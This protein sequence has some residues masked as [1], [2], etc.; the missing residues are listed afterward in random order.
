MKFD[1]RN[2]FLDKCIDLAKFMLDNGSTKAWFTWAYIHPV[3]AAVT[4]MGSLALLATPIDAL[5]Q[6]SMKAHREAL[7]LLREYTDVLCTKVSSGGGQIERTFDAK[8]SVK[9][10]NVL[11]K[12]VDL[13][14]EG[15]AKYQDTRYN[16]VLRKDLAAAIQESNRCRLAVLELFADRLLPDKPAPPGKPLP[17]VMFES[18][19]KLVDDL[20]VY[21]TSEECLESLAG[22]DSKWRSASV[23]LR[24]LWVNSYG[25]VRPSR[26]GR[27]SQESLWCMSF[28]EIEDVG[29]ARFGSPTRK[30]C[31]LS[32]RDCHEAYNN[33][34]NSS[35]P[36]KTVFATECEQ[37]Y[38]YELWEW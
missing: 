15:G 1:T 32:I 7:G 28:K 2:H 5:G 35:L 29:G 16:G 9:L 36:K 31:Q 24:H 6:Q 3:I 30:V 17:Y 4:I 38:A 33:A 23:L 25:K 27:L 21:A 11:K 14:L 37:F 13:G 19:G 10:N 20:G 8:A 12:L 22:H 34:L 26:C 18:E